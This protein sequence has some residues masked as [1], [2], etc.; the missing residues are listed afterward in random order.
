MKDYKEKYGPWA[1][2]TGASS[3]IGAEFAKQLAEK[4]LN[5]VL[6]ARREDR[7][8]ELAKEIQQNHDI[9]VKTI[10]VD[11]LSDGFIDRIRE[12]TDGLDIGLLVSNAG[13]RIYVGEYFDNPL[14]EELD[15]IDLNI[16]VPAILTHHFAK[17][18]IARQKGGIIYNASVLGY[19]G[20]PYAAS[21]AGSK[22]YG[23]VQGEGL[24]YELK[25][26]GVDVLVLNPG[27]T[28]TEMTAPHDFSPLPMK[29]M[30]PGPVAK[31]AIEAL[32]KRSRVTPGGMNKV[33][34]WMSKFMMTRN[35]N[36]RMF[37]FF[38]KK[39]LKKSHA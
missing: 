22:A 20:T 32:G 24:W 23:L 18:M 39:V 2:I 21:Y 38:L 12:T 1:L 26:K 11:L 27:L 19:M 37:G 14:K 29:L 31:S 13:Y 4:G 25:P 34:N 36:T 7:L 6:A 16:K 9:Q 17:D 33:S 35:M 8:I 30:M 3:G 28:N 15:M 5:L 10:Q